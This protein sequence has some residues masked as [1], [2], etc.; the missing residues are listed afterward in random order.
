MIKLFSTWIQVPQRNQSDLLRAASGCLVTKLQLVQ[1]FN[2]CLRHRGVVPYLSSRR[3]HITIPTLPRA[4]SSSQRTIV[5]S[6]RV[7]VYF[8]W[9]TRTPAT[10]SRCASAGLVSLSVTQK[11]LLDRSLTAAI[12]CCHGEF[13]SSQSKLCRPNCAVP[14]RWVRSGPTSPR[15]QAV[16]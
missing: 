7:R 16:M 5:E 6:V 3:R 2:D 14:P 4:A 15:K 11:S 1:V 13:L 9:G 12:H 8:Y 10:N